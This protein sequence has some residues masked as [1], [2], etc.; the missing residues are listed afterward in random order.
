MVSHPFLANCWIRGQNIL[1]CVFSDNTV[2]MMW[3]AIRKL[4]IDTNLS[5]SEHCTHMFNTIK[6]SSNCSPQNGITDHDPR[7]CSTRRSKERSRICT[8]GWFVSCIMDKNILKEFRRARVLIFVKI[9]TYISKIPNHSD[10][11]YHPTILNLLWLIY[12][13]KVNYTQKV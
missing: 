5:S 7:S 12:T 10:C 6:G 4:H 2:K 13:H 1:H 8:I 11:A 9:K 3:T